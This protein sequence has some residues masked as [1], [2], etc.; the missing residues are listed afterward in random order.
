MTA[1]EHRT[2]LM[3]EDEPTLRVR[4]PHGI[5]YVEI[6]T[7]NVHGPTGHPVV[8]VEVIS[9]SV[10]T[11]AQDGRLYEQRCNHSHNMIY[12]VGIPADP[13]TEGTHP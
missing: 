2:I 6:R 1:N 9:N 11:P 5:G 10:D 8:A 13:A 12:M 4:L 7:G 3:H